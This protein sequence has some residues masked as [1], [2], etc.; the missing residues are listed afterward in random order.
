M[1][2]PNEIGS[3]FE[4][5]VKQLLQQ[6]QA[7]SA[8]HVTIREQVTIELNDGRQVRPD[9]ELDVRVDPLWVRLLIECQDRQRSAPSIVD[10]I[11]GLRNQSDRSLVLFLYRDHLPDVT[12]RTLNNHGVPHASL[13]QFMD[14]VE[15]LISLFKHESMGITEEP[16]LHFKSKN[17]A[18]KPLSPRIAYD[19]LRLAGIWPPEDC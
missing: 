3:R 18:A 7:D 16:L 8:G 13:A 5:D 1:T 17:A 6:L 12:A 9:F 14:Y 11:L 2:T 15:K 4:D 19:A 10:K